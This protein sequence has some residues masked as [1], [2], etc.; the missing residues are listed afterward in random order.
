MTS[1]FLSHSSKDKFFVRELAERLKSYGIRVW[2]DEAELKIGDS[3]TQKIAQ[4]ID[5]MD[6]VGV[7]LSSNSVNSEWVQRELQVASQKELSKR[8]VVVLPILLEP[9]EIPFF[10]KDKLYADFSTPE[11]F[12]DS[13]CRLL[14]ALGVPP[15]KIKPMR[16][17]QQERKVPPPKSSSAEQQLT[18]F[19]DILI[20]D[21]DDGRSYRP[22]PDKL[23]Y[24]MYLKLSK[25]PPTEWGQI[26]EAERRFPRHTM[27]RRA[28]I[29]GQHIVIHCVPDELEKYH[30]ADLREDVKNSNTKYRQYLTEIAQQEVKEPNQEKNEREKIRELRRRL[31]FG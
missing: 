10:L 8:K 13:F 11:K 15:E 28:W 12:E 19:E 18:T 21:L 24:N 3:L 4:A 1:I 20:V 29:E 7:I 26:F 27:W 17:P 5:E 23:L 14:N 30:L 22:D 6:F 31:G 9:V 2:L 16:G 25:R